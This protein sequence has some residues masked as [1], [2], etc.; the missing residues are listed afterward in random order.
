MV[1]AVNHDVQVAALHEQLERKDDQDSISSA[2]FPMASPSVEECV[3]CS[4]AELECKLE[5]VLGSVTDE[6]AD[7]IGREQQHLL[8]M[9]ASAR[10]PLAF[11]PYCWQ[12]LQ[13]R[14]QSKRPTVRLSLYHTSAQL[15]RQGLC[16]AV[17]VGW[18]W[19]K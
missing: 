13:G 18:A 15:K 3:R 6:L 17:P 10:A 4:V 12:T 2:V 16:I 11:G 19:W 1:C 9:Q 8:L 14:E 5:H 7:E